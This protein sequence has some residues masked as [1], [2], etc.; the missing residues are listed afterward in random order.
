MSK[1]D[2]DK[3][4]RMMYPASPDEQEDDVVAMSPRPIDA[5]DFG[6]RFLFLFL[7]LFLTKFAESPTPTDSHVSH[8][9]THTINTNSH[10]QKTKTYGSGCL[11]PLTTSI[12]QS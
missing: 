10:T 9:H 11:L 5:P 1:E 8:T 6:V 4:R 2:V 3:Q 7:K 12:P